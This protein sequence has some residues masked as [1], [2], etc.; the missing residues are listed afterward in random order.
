MTDLTTPLDTIRGALLRCSRSDLR[1]LRDE[2]AA[3][4]AKLEREDHRRVA[5]EIRRLARS[6]GASAALTYASRKPGR[7]RRS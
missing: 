7:P 6:I 5:G 3:C 2:I 1:I 4:D